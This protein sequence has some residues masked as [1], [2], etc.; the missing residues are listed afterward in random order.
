[1]LGGH[2]TS[3]TGLCVFRC[4]QHLDQQNPEQAL[5]AC[6]RWQVFMRLKQGAERHSGQSN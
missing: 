4:K 6:V 2:L 5:H 3:K 1:M